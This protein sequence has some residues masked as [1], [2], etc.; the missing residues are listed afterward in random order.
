MLDLSRPGEIFIDFREFQGE[1]VRR[2]VMPCGGLWQP[3]AAEF[4]PFKKIVC[5]PAALQ[6]SS[7]D[8]RRAGRLVG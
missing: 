7:H 2:P 8:G 1:K 4:G 3:F 6:A 5:E